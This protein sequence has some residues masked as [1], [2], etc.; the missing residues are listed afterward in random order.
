MEH[1]RRAIAGPPVIC[2]SHVQG[3]GRGKAQCTNKSA[4]ANSK[5]LREQR[6]AESG[7]PPM[8]IPPIPELDMKRLISA[9]SCL[10]LSASYNSHCVFSLPQCNGPPRRRHHPPKTTRCQVLLSIS[11]FPAYT[12]QLILHNVAC[13]RHRHQEPAIVIGPWK[14][15]GPARTRFQV[16]A[17][18]ARAACGILLCYQVLLKM[19]L[20]RPVL[21]RKLRAQTGG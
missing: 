8:V 2:W 20:F 5:R 15:A 6:K 19:T 16:P 1:R 17:C 14:C 21:R 10:S 12:T 9:P 7:A 11:V 3:L 18:A 13:V 4:V